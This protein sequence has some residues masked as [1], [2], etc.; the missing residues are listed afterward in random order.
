MQESNGIN[1]SQLKYF[2]ERLTEEEKQTALLQ[3]DGL[4]NTLNDANNN[5][6]KLYS[7]I[8]ASDNEEDI[9]NTIINAQN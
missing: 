9:I 1:R 6:D 3:M 4:L 5:Y 7:I 8:H 2:G